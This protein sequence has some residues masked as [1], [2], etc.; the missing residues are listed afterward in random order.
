MR[1]LDHHEI[2]DLASAMDTPYEAM[3]LLGAYGGLRFGEV[4]AL[5]TNHIDF[6]RRTVEIAATLNEVQGRI[7]I[8]PP[9]TLRSRGQVALPEFVCGELAAHISLS[10]IPMGGLLFT[11]PEGGPL[12]RHNW[13]RRA[14][15]PAV[16]RSIGEPCTFHDLRHSS[17]A[18]L[19]KSGQHAKVIQERLGHA[20]IKTTLDVYGHLFP[21]MDEAAAEALNESARGVGV[22]LESLRVAP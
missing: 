2:A 15:K 3:V 13:R 19:I 10:S 17:A 22:G 18:L 12:R 9:K 16:A 7:V 8:G 14:W 21:G 6:L 5:R 4:A 1:I 11:A 20:S